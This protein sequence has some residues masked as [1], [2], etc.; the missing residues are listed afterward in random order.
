MRT[1][2]LFLFILMTGSAAAQ[3]YPLKPIRLI[4]PFPAGGG[5]DLAARPL[6][7][8]LA[9]A[10]GQPVLVE[11]RP[12]GNTVIGTEA[13]A[14]SAPD[15]YTLLVTGSSTMTI[16]PFVLAKLPY[17]PLV[18][19]APIS[20]V[21]RF[22]FFVA[23]PASLPASSLQELI[24]HARSKPGQLSYATNGS[25]TVGHLGMETL[26]LAAGVDLVHVPYKGFVSAMPDL[27]SGRV[28]V[29][30][31]DLGVVGEQ[32]RAGKLRL[33]AATSAQRYGMLPEVPTIAESGFPGYE[34]DVWFGFYAPARTPADII[35]R[36]GVEARKYLSSPEAKE[37]Y[38]RLGYETAPSTPDQVR[39][40]IV[41]EQ[42]VNAAAVKAANLKPE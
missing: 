35:A 16:Q 12:G 18:D 20:V 21:A 19:F 15:G 33:L 34:F 31:A 28:A 1:I 29:M 3:T 40:K 13:V 17:D 39:A 7:Q 10:L 4:I 38:A 9:L 30:L 8:N 32:A 24:A 41:S 26:K 36:L 11:S 42:R 14:K 37:T 5:A 22:P 27:V 23:V 2:F 6:A 25:G